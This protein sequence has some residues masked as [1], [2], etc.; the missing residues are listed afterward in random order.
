MIIFPAIDI[1]DGQC[2]RLYKGEFSKTEVVS[3]DI[4]QT[5]KNLQRDGAEFIHMVDL[6]GALKGE[7]ENLE[8]I[9]DILRNIDIPVELG[10]G[11]RSIETIEKVLGLGINRV[12]LGTSALNNRELVIEAVRKYGE[13]IVVGIDANN[14]KVAVEGWVKISNVDYIEFAKNIEQLGVKTIIFT[15]I[16]RDGTLNGPNLEQLDEINRSVSCDIIASGGIKNIGDIINIKRL[17]IYGAITGKAI[18][19]G[20][21]DLKEAIIAGREG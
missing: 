9:S 10:G 1:K 7:P 6:D 3:R 4:I 8:T 16:S 5:A 2:V 17:D 20:T 19:S 21:L 18:Y 12:I 14:R 11:I 15:D 13:K